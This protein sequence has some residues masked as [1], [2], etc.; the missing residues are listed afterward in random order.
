MDAGRRH[1]PQHPRTVADRNPA[2]RPNG[3][4]RN[5]SPRHM[6]DPAH[7]AQPVGNIHSRLPHGQLPHRETLTCPLGRQPL[8]PE[9]NK[10]RN[11]LTL[12]GL[13]ICR[14]L[15]CKRRHIASQKATFR[16]RKDHLWQRERPPFTTQPEITPTPGRNRP[17]GD[18]QITTSLTI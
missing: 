15:P 10:Q 13:A 14:L 9:K 12:N 11:T 4:Q 8:H 2:A 16:R 5:C 6:A 17:C 18:R 3:N 1:R 7:C